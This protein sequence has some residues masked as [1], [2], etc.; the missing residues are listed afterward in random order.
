[1]AEFL[2]K[3]S[4]GDF[5]DETILVKG[6]P[7]FEFEQILNLLEAKQ[8][9]TVEEVD[10]NALAHNFKFFRSFLKPETKAVGMVKASGY[11]A[12][13]YTARCRLRLSGCGS[14]R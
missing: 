11:G 2:D 9:Q 4:T 8:H 13:S 10:L 14:A 7:E 12:G 5:E 3:K 1:M 6:A